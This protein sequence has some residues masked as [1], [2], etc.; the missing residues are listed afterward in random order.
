M[1][2]V[3][4]YSN[5]KASLKTFGQL[6]GPIAPENFQVGD[7]VI[8]RIWQT[9]KPLNGNDDSLLLKITELTA[10]EGDSFLLFPPEAKGA[11]PFQ[12]TSDLLIGGDV[13]TRDL[14]RTA[15][16]LQMRLMLVKEI[17]KNNRLLER[18]PEEEKF[19]DTEVALELTESSL[20]QE[21][22]EIFRPTEDHIVIHDFQVFALLPS[23]DD[24]FPLNLREAL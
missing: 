18:A 11:L 3:N 12:A 2:L 5:K 15:D 22:E 13:I 16:I 24:G 4:D 7:F 20:L 17:V 9:D 23:G 10:G 8:T 21:L 19:Q 6:H 14:E 1:S